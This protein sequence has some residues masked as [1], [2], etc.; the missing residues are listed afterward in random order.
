MARGS[1]KAKLVRAGEVNTTGLVAVKPPVQ[2]SVVVEGSDTTPEEERVA[3]RDAV[4]AGRQAL[5]VLYK[6]HADPDLEAAKR[7]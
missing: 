5:S 1:D 7:R 4:R 3:S 6:P 2:E